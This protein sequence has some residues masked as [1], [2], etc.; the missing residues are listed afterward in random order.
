MHAFDNACQHIQNC[1]GFK[2]NVCLH[3]C[4]DNVFLPNFR[5]ACQHIQNCNECKDRSISLKMYV[6][7][8]KTAMDNYCLH[9]CQENICMPLIM[10]RDWDQGWP[11]HILETKT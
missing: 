1:N 4:P 3:E 10:H 9:E 5:I 6:N 11:F 7:R 2:D 8:F